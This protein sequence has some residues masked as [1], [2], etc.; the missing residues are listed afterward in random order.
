MIVCGK[1]GNNCCNGGYGVVD[2][3]ECPDCPSAYEL[4]KEKD[5][6]GTWGFQV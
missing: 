6:L 3:K 5:T 2:G 4:Q 1:C